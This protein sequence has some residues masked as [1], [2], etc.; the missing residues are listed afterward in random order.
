[1]H[2]FNAEQESGGSLSL[3]VCCTHKFSGQAAMGTSCGAGKRLLDAA[4]AEH[5][6]W[7]SA[8]ALKI[9]RFSDEKASQARCCLFL[10]NHYGCLIQSSGA[11]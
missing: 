9:I 3:K 10:P 8:A 2:T 4:V 11:A 7:D 1:M 5:D 6:T